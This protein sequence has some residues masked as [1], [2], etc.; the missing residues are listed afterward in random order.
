[1]DDFTG[2]LAVF[3]GLVSVVMTL[4][5]AFWWIYW[6]Y[7]KKQLQYHERQLMIERGLTPPPDL[8][9]ERGMSTPEDALRRGTVMLFLGVGFGVAYIVLANAGGDGPPPWVAGTAAGIV[10]FLGCGYLIYYF[11]ARRA[12]AETPDKTGMPL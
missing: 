6:S 12:A 1:M 11:V 10:G 4:G 2:V 5:I 9:A 3:T 8:P 7:R